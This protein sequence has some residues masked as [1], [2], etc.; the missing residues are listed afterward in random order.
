[1]QFWYLSGSNYSYSRGGGWFLKTDKS[2]LEAV[3]DK[4]FNFAGN[5]RV[6]VA[7]L[8]QQQSKQRLG[9]SISSEGT[10]FPWTVT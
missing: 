3:T 10:D 5:K 6:A 1:M 4:L 7:G 2:S 9:F 8:K